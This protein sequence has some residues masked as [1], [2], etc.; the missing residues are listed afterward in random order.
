MNTSDPE[1]QVSFWDHLEELRKRI[2]RSLLVAVGFAIVLFI[3][4]QTLFDSI[5]FAPAKTDFFL[6]RWLCIVGNK[7]EIKDLCISSISI[8]LMNTE[9]AGQF[10]G[11]I[12]ASLI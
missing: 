9:I 10:R 8:N 5:L 3:Y 2:I 6:Y 11:H 4:K 7:F 1:K 12:I